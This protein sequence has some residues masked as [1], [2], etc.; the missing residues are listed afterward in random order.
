LPDARDEFKGLVL[1]PKKEISL[2]DR[3]I[4]TKNL[5]GALE[6]DCK[7]NEKGREGTTEGIASK[8]TRKPSLKATQKQKM[9]RT[10]DREEAESME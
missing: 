5:W 7:D 1:S 3:G 9:E 2:Y 6:T 10:R 4:K 8:R